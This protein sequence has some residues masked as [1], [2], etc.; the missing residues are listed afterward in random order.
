MNPARFSTRTSGDLTADRRYAYGDGALADGDHIA[1]R[2]LFEQTLELVP[3]WPP[4]HFA[5]ARA[6]LALGEMQA[7]CAALNRA[8]ALDAGDRLGAGV[9]LAQITG[10]TAMPDAYVAGLFDEYADR[11]DSHLVG[12]LK[13]RAPEVLAEMLHR[14]RGEAMQFAH[15]L[16]LG[17]GTGLMARALTGSGADFTG[18][19]LSS[20]MV[21]IAEASGLYKR[22]E[23]A[24]LLAFLRSEPAASCDLALAADVFCYVPDLL[25]VFVEVRRALQPGGVFA[26]SIQTHSGEGVIIGADSRV[27]HAP[28]LVRALADEAG[29]I[30]RQEIAASTR[31][32]R[33]APV[34][35]ALFLLAPGACCEKVETDFS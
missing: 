14:E 10:G 27:H 2:D 18:V 32:D 31:W 16:D 23:C 20:R 21:E 3:N 4:A 28:T 33:G 19:D 26:F 1:A 13:Y 22:L 15:A 8:Q 9:L 11:F 35:G 34:E 29:L 30:I 7:A 12:A 6:C 25:P 24:E 5:L 17:C